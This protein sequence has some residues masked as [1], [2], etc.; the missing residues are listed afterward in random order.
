M[1]P[2]FQELGVDARWNIIE[3][4]PE[5]Y[6]VT[7]KF[8]NLLHG[9][10]EQICEAEYCLFTEVTRQNL[11]HMKIQGDT[12]FIHDPQLAGLIKRKNDLGKIGYGDVISIYHTPILRS[13]IFCSP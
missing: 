4:T 11:E 8:H 3:G 9:R 2:L 6:Q 13:G 7:K 12:L 5:F 1:V 10:R